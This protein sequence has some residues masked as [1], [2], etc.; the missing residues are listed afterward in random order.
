MKS[1]D[2]NKKKPYT[3]PTLKKIQLAPDEAV[4]AGCK[5]NLG[6]GSVTCT[7]SRGCGSSYGT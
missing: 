3:K 5:N 6:P 4:L 1:E 2:K 7:P